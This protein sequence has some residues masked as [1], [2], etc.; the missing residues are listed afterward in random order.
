MRDLFVIYKTQTSF[1]IQT[2]T[3][4]VPHQGTRVCNATMVQTCGWY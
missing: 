1:T 3:D 4:S 2:F